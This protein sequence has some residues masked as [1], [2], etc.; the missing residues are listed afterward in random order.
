[1]KRRSVC[2]AAFAMIS[3]SAG[4]ASAA[5]GNYVCSAAYV[6]GSSSVGSH[7]YVTVT[8]FSG[9]DCTGTFLGGFFLCSSN[10]TS[11]VCSNQSTYLATSDSEIATMA[12]KVIDAA[13]W[14]MPVTVDTTSCIG[15]GFGCVKQVN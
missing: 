10:A 14:N 4:A 1:M 5:T 2:L 8:V 15:G 12:T 11:S 13:Q 9:P 7:G 3:L 6:P